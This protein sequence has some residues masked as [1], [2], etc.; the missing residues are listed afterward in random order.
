M[1]VK[2]S[3]VLPWWI[4]NQEDKPTQIAF[5]EWVQANMSQENIKVNMENDYS[6]VSI[7][8][9]NINIKFISVEVN[10]KI[11]YYFINNINLIASS[12]YAMN[13]VID[14]WATYFMNA[15]FSINPNANVFI[16]RCHNLTSDEKELTKTQEDNILDNIKP[17]IGN[18]DTWGESEFKKIQVGQEQYVFSNSDNVFYKGVGDWYTSLNSV[19]LYQHPTYVDAYVMFP[20]PGI[21]RQGFNFK[22]YD[23]K[24]QTITSYGNWKQCYI[25][26]NRNQS[27]MNNFIGVFSVPNWLIMSFDY[28]ELNIAGGKVIGSSIL[29]KPHNLSPNDLFITTSNNIY[30][31]N[32]NDLLSPKI[33]DYIPIFYGR[34]KINSTDFNNLFSNLQ[35][36]NNMYVDYN[37]NF[38]VY[39]KNKLG[40]LDS[41]AKKLPGP[42]KSTVDKY[43]EYIAQNQNR[44]NSGIQSATLGLVQGAGMIGVGAASGNVYGAAGGFQ[45][46]IGSGTSI[47]N[48]TATILDMK[49]SLIPR[50]KESYIIDN[51]YDLPEGDIKPMMQHL[52]IFKYDL[53]NLVEYNNA[54][55]LYGFEFNNLKKFKDAII[56]GFGA[57]H[58]FVSFRVDFYKK[59][60][61]KNY[62]NIPLRFQDEYFNL[63]NNGIRLW[64]TQEMEFI[65]A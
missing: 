45:Q 43:Q 46:I 17:I 58:C 35:K 14:L 4:N 40:S 48:Q 63:L 9:K 39:Y 3:E 13:L 23:K 62:Q 51:M 34:D 16:K 29:H 12:T 49:N 47:L 26:I 42:L 28:Y 33:I 55:V 11:Y 41:W 38:V 59:M 30:L 20:L 54:I 8:T 24:T 31:N 60:F 1:I 44:I 22:V 64:N 18:I 15:F 6:N 19:A 57:N 61:Y 2:Y 53:K 27:F 65:N 7:L 32:K 25:E 10:N 21:Y 56:N 5:N 37:G 52:M 36:M 50:Q